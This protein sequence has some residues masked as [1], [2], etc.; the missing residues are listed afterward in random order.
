M[1]KATA[2][3]VLLCAAVAAAAAAAA[4]AASASITP[5]LTLDQSAGMAAGSTVNL[6]M[7]LKFAPS[8][9]DS[10]K[11]LTLNLP[12]GLLAN[13]SIDGGA[14]LHTNTPMAACQVG[15]GT[16]TAVPVVAGLP[17]PTPVSVPITFDLVAPP[18]PGDLAGL[19]IQATVLGQTSELGTPGEITVRSTTDAAGFGLNIRF[20]GIPDSFA[21]LGP[22]GAQIAVDE[23]S[24]TLTGVRLPTS[25]PATPANVTV[26]ADSY[27]AP[28]TARTASAPLHVTGCSSL[29]FTPAFHITAAKD[30]GDAGVQV[31]TDI[32]QPAKP[33]QSTSRTVALTLPSSV[34]SPNVQAVLNGGIMC[35]DPSF[36]TC[37]SVGSATSTSPLYPTAL[38]GRAYLT[39]PLTSPVIALVFPPPF[40]LTLRGDVNLATSTTTFDN[41]PDIPLTDLQVTL[42]GGP[43][44][45]FET[46]C[47]QPSGTASSTLIAQNGDRTVV[48]SAPFTVSRCTAAGGVGGG[49]GGGSGSQP[50][51]G[52]S[53]TSK[54]AKPG[55]PLIGSVSL[56]GLAQG[57]P[58]LSFTVLAGKGAPGI[59]SLTLKLPRGL[60]FAAHRRHGRLR[61]TRV[62]IAGGSVKSIALARGRLIITLRRAVRRVSVKLGPRALRETHALER[63][64]RS[65]RIRSVTLT[66]GIVDAGGHLTTVPL[67]IRYA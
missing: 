49:T 67:R 25:C 5:S 29:P 66:F 17:V 45:V 52:G 34:L 39:G 41:V 13:A 6:G 22:V 19:A 64:A 63:A 51:G 11:D 27:Q 43:N 50:G 65:G 1:V 40:S 24:S 2:R 26:T 4:P 7:D 33:A 46:S 16:V 60:G 28:T 14:C 53:R 36:A 47:A 42:A 37:R 23:L 57:A 48:E 32:T 54:H 58:Q 31:V 12:A 18:N 62:S 61:L 9:S 15:T 35:T 21:L 10:P 56:S 38:S 59:R 8:G 3:R 30:A 20:S 44:A 55:R